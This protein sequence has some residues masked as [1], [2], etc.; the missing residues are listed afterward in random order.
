[1]DSSA[2]SNKAR[3]NTA[4]AETSNIK[5][6]ETFKDKEVDDISEAVGGAEYV[7]AL[8]ESVDVSAE[9][10]ETMR[11]KASEDKKGGSTKGDG[12]AAAQTF[13]PAQIKAQLLKN[14]P[15]EPLMRKQIE[16][17]IRKEIKYLHRRALKLM[18]STGNV[19]Y[20]EMNN[21]LRKIRELKGILAYLLKHSVEALKT[22]WLRF[23]HGV[24]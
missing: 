2:L 5:K 9:V 16:K 22:L 21:M 3:E 12:S 1:M 18:T 17:E 11:K 6:A 4:S 10:S 23:V 7:D 24:L 13:D 19:S 14:I 20:F 8:G 15:S